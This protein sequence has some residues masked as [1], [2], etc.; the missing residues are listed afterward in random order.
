LESQLD[1]PAFAR[2][3]VCKRHKQ[4]ETLIKEFDER[5][6]KLVVPKE[7]PLGDQVGRACRFSMIGTEKMKKCA[8][9]VEARFFIPDNGG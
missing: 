4:E 8:I 5:A 1:D 7:L 3:R 6:D 2:L 9:R